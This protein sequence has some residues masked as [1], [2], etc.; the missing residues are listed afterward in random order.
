MYAGLE[1]NTKGEGGREGEGEG[2]RERESIKR[3]KESDS[4]FFLSQKE[5]KQNYMIKKLKTKP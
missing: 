3:M 5:F 2:E 1:N 4:R